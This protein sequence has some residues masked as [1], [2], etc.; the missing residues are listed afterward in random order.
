MRKTLAT[1]KEA[2]FKNYNRFTKDDKK[3]AKKDDGEEKR[4]RY[5]ASKVVVAQPDED[6]MVIQAK[7]VYADNMNPAITG[8]GSAFTRL[9]VSR[10]LVN[11]LRE[12]NIS[13]PSTIQQLAIPEILQQHKDVLFVSQTGTGKTLAYLLPIMQILKQREM[14]G[15][16]AVEKV[17]AKVSEVD[18]QD[19]ASLAD[20]AASAEPK[21]HTTRLPGRPRAIILVPTRELVLQVTAVA[22][23]L[24]HFEKMSV[25]GISG[26]GGEISKFVKLF[27]TQPI[28]VLVSTPGVLMSLIDKRE[29]FFGKLEYLIVDEA[30][31]MFTTGKGFEEDMT[32]ILAPLEYRLANKGPDA[33]AK[34]ITAVLCSATLTEPLMAN[35]K[36]LLP[37]VVKVA[38]PLVHMSLNTLEQQFLEVSGT[39]D[40][41]E[42]LLRAVQPSNSSKIL[43]FCNTPASCRSTEHF[44]TENGFSATSL[45]GEI[46]ARLRASNWRKFLESDKS[47][48]SARILV[49]TD[50]ASRGIDVS[51]VDHVVL[52]DFPSN[53]IDYLHRI[54]RTARAGHKGTVTCII[55][56]K[57]RVLAIAIQ[58][59]LKRGDSLESLSSNKRLNP[60]HSS[61]RS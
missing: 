21:A 55:A 17:E 61:R 3:D 27:K 26:G 1:T 51:T 50:I 12:M 53:P 15:M 9:G 34:P 57:D 13:I 35:I 52:F 29:I 19:P 59:A 11:G 32:K 39:G 56:K 25:T 28:D 48:D 42:A 6:V 14:A 23:K 7:S 54:G 46:P 41:H 24:S 30:D 49:C 36:R 4:R 47:K 18:I 33:V 2:G 45:H 43:V 22:K 58:E 38:T 20:D 40:K 16:P 60:L 10:T 5:K 44:L 37:S 31:S 8:T